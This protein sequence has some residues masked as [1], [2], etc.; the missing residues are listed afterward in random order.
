M[1]DDLNINNTNIYQY[2]NANKRHTTRPGLVGLTLV[3]VRKIRLRSSKWSESACI[4]FF[5]PSLLQFAAVLLAA[6]KRIATGVLCCSSSSHTKRVACASRQKATAL[7]APRCQFNIINFSQ[8]QRRPAA[9]LCA[10]RRH[11]SSGRRAGHAKDNAKEVPPGHN[12]LLPARRCWPLRCRPARVRLS[13]RLLAG[14]P[15]WRRCVSK[16]FTVSVPADPARPG[17]AWTG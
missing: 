6:Q 11:A 7:L 15:A 4:W 16:F 13:V 5:G 12:G 10:L 14:R 9:R 17:L 8:L 3:F 2:G 1:F